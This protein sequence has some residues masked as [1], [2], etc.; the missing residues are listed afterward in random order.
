MAT[1]L[2]APWE[3]RTSGL[4]VG[5]GAREGLLGGGEDRAQP[6]PRQGSWGG[7]GALRALTG[8]RVGSY[9]T[10][11]LTGKIWGIIFGDSTGKSCNSPGAITLKN[12]YRIILVI[13]SP[14]RVLHPHIL[15]LGI[16]EM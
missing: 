7:G 4:G 15:V 3:G 12:V 14:Q 13:T 2:P 5:V 9:R 10:G 11:A 1:A 16:N 8:T 6:E